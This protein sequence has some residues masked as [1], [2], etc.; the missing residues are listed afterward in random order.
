MLTIP[1]QEGFEFSESDHAYT[2]N[3]A[4]VLSITQILRDVG[5]SPDFGAMNQDLL[6]VAA[7][8]GTHVHAICEY[9][10]YDDL[11]E[12]DP[13]YQGYLDGWIRFRKESGF[14]PDI[15]EAMLF[16]PTYRFSGRPDAAGKLGGKLAVVEI[17]SGEGP[18]LHDSIGC[19]L[20]A[21]QILIE[22]IAKYGPIKTRVAVKLHE[23]GTYTQRTY[24]DH[25]DRGVFLAAVSVAN[26]KLGR[27]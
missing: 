18:T 25:R 1:R 10:D 21:Q 14:I 12:Y 7:L 17:K 15:R 20:A 23:N 4:R 16:H 5:I 24:T 13:K 8:R 27:K 6:A 9:Y 2:F 11:G 22:D 3:G 19:Q 26:Y